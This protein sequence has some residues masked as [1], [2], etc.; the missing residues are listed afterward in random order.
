MQAHMCSEVGSALR[1]AS[2]EQ[3]GTVATVLSSMRFRQEPYE[4]VYSGF[5]PLLL[6]HVVAS[7]CVSLL[8]GLCL[9]VHLSSQRDPASVH[10]HVPLERACFNDERRGMVSTG[11]A[12][13]WSPTVWRKAL[14]T[15]LCF[16]S[17]KRACRQGMSVSLATLL[18]VLLRRLG[19]SAG[20]HFV[21]HRAPSRCSLARAFCVSLRMVQAAGSYFMLQPRPCW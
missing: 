12:V 1:P 5:K 20:L 2:A 11:D 7:R 15:P 16:A 3:L 19:L 6:P 4:W 10:A 9:Y 18:L 14:R 21:E 13:L 8:P 17:C